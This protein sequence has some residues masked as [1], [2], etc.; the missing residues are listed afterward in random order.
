M[1]KYLN[2]NIVAER[3][4]NKKLLAE[5][6]R[7]ERENKRLMDAL[8]KLNG[9]SMRAINDETRRCSTMES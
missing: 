5:I 8:I 7:L 2:D 4:K 6:K 1:P 9:I 3:I